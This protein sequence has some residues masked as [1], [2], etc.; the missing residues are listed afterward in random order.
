MGR[1]LDSRF[2]RRL[3]RR[4]RKATRGW[5]L[6][7]VVWFDAG[8][9]YVVKEQ[10]TSA[11]VRLIH[12]SQQDPPVRIGRYC[13]INE[14]VQV[15]PGGIH[16]TDR[17]T[18]FLFGQAGR[19]GIPGLSGIEFKDEE[20]ASASNGPIVIG[21]DVWMAREVIVLSGVTVGD[22]AVVAAGA[23]VTSDVAPYEI[24][25]GVPAHHLKWRFDSE[26]RSGLCEVAWWRW[27]LE[28]VLTHREALTSGDVAGFVR[29]HTTGSAD[30]CPL[31]GPAT[32]KDVD[33]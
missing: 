33:G 13:S 11:P 29:Q 4:L 5:A 18:T 3:E 8:P 31:C 23:V 25:G 28:K 27:P 1:M 6:G 19:D 9:P 24:V 32:K 12:H 15:I 7:H 17:V 21:N 20:D 16:A 10:P 22:G 2:G 14:T 30:S 26:T